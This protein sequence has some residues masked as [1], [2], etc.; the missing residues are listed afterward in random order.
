MNYRYEELY[1]ELTQKRELSSLEFAYV[2]CFKEQAEIEHDITV[3]LQSISVTSYM[4]LCEAKL[5]KLDRLA[6]LY[7]FIN[8]Y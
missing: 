5:K 7:N 8:N 2:T 6:E 4:A 1:N 3:F